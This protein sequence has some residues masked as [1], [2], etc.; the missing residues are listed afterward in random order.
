MPEIT[1]KSIALGNGETLGYREREGGEKTLLLIHGNM[2]S[3]KHWDLV[4]ENI[5]S[6][7]KLY[8]IDLRGFGISTYNTPI[9]SLKDLTNDVKLFVDAIGLSTFSVMGW[10]SPGGGVSMQFAAEY[11]HYVENLILLASIS[12]RG[13]PFF[14]SDGMGNPILT[15]RLTT[16]EEIANEK[17]KIQPTVK[18][19]ESKDKAFLKMVWKWLI[20]N[21]NEPDSER[22]EEYLADMLTQRNYIDIVH[23]NNQFNISNKHNGVVEGSN[24]IAKIKCPTLILYGENDIVVP[25]V[26]TEQLIQDF[27]GRAEVVMLKNCGHSPLVDDLPQLLGSI[28]QFLTKK[29]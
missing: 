9:A 10:S 19:I 14:N 7:Y 20:Y 8:A 21:H 27:K 29:V 17:G 13:Y 22:F 12:S 28:E 16:R 3:S 4:M 23:A 6:S 1:L 25:T 5:D 18:A 2:T 26:M 11:P 15:E 24:D